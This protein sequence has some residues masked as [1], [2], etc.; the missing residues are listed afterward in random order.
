MKTNELLI[1]HKFSH[2]CPTHFVLCPVHFH[3]WIHK[4]TKQ[5]S[6]TVCLDRSA[7]YI[8]NLLSYVK[9]IGF[10]ELC[11][12]DVLQNTLGLVTPIYQKCWI[13]NL[14]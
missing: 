4:E 13:E 12:L 9:N 14:K 11:H 5:T 10:E 8:I 6:V 2:Y 1:R 3:W 7:N